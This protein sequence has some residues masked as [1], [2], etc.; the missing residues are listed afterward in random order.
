MSKGIAG[1][2]RQSRPFRSKEQE[3]VLG[4]RLVA[5][6]VVEPWEQFLRREADL[7]TNQYNILRILRGSH[8]DRLQ[9]GEIGARMIH[10][11]P[12]ITRLVDRLARRG[13]VARV[14]GRRDRRVVE[15][16][17]TEKGLALLKE[18]DPH[19]ERYTVAMVGHL[20]PKKLAQLGK[21][22]DEVLKPAKVFP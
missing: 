18:L 22:L 11:D 17:I 19:A 1:A 8:P 6:R 9:S 3:V 4:L 21:L 12:D 10:R 13:L 2:L 14:R 7:G 16:G 5:A 20:G 15:I